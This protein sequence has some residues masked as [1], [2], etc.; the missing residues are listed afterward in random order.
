MKM[1][2]NLVSS[3]STA[4]ESNDQHKLN[5][6]KWKDDLC[7]NIYYTKPWYRVEISKL[8][9]E[10]FKL[11]SSVQQDKESFSTDHFEDILPKLI[12][13]LSKDKQA[14]L[15]GLD[16]KRKLNE[17][18][19]IDIKRLE[20]FTG[21]NISNLSLKIEEEKGE[22]SVRRHRVEGNCRGVEFQ[23]TF[24]V[25]ESILQDEIR[26]VLPGKFVLR[27]LIQTDLL[28]RKF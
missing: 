24:L 7:S 9:A 22:V 26:C 2:G 21:L 19:E 17:D 25:K 14:S 10:I 1:E 3:S 15:E 18:G 5:R 20:K 12:N 11:E 23:T 8:E 27:C 4:I 28:I 6:E 16:V 13:K